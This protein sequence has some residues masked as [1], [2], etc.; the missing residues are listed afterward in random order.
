MMELVIAG[1]RTTVSKY[2]NNFN[3]HY[4]KVRSNGC[5]FYDLNLRRLVHVTP[6]S[7]LEIIPLY[8]KGTLGSL[9]FTQEWT[10]LKMIDLESLKIIKVP[11][12][13]EP[14]K[15]E[16]VQQN[17]Q[18][19]DRITELPFQYLSLIVKIVPWL[20]QFLFFPVD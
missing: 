7:I 6:P 10:R 4:N 17:R 19:I 8:L 3:S 15:S 16:I 9:L 1:K 12:S 13:R 20:R 11:S 18:V 14:T 5:L 2:H